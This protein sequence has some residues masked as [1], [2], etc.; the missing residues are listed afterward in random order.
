MVHN[1]TFW[2][3]H[4]KKLIYFLEQNLGQLIK[5]DAYYRPTPTQISNHFDLSL[6]FQQLSQV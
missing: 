5:H 2:F 4:K 3:R 1:I 6:L